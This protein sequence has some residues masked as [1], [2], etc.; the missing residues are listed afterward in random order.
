MGV[1][2]FNGATMLFGEL[3]LVFLT[4]FGRNVTT[5]TPLER[6]AIWAIQL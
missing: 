5:P 2:A 1:T 4:F 6:S 3:H